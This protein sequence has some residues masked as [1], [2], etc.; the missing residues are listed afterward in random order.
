MERII[1]KRFVDLNDKNNC[2]NLVIQ[3]GAV[4]DV[5]IFAQKF[6]NEKNVAGLVPQR[7]Y[8]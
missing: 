8:R 5:G 4:A 3:W 6:G 1:E 7:I 2:L